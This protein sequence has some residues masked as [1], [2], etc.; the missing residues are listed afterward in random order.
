MLRNY[1]IVMIHFTLFYSICY[2]TSSRPFL[3]SLIDI[4]QIFRAYK[5]EKN[6]GAAKKVALQ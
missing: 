3:F 2:T 4:H 1:I 5:A 6:S